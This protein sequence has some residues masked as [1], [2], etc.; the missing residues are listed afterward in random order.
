[1]YPQICP[2]LAVCGP[3]LQ[4]ASEMHLLC[5]LL[6]ALKITHYV[7]QIP[8]APSVASLAVHQIS[9]SKLSILMLYVVFEWYVVTSRRV[10]YLLQVM[11]VASFVLQVTTALSH[12]AACLWSRYCS[13]AGIFKWPCPL[14]FC[15]LFRLPAHDCSTMRGNSAPTCH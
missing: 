3:A 2:T 9:V 1:M 5:C 10:V 15:F 14:G 4:N 8:S 6:S 11:N 7:R 12:K 13:G